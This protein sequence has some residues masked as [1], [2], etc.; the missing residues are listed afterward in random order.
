MNFM[1]DNYSQNIKWDGDVLKTLQPS[2]TRASLKY[3]IET[4]WKN[5]PV[6]R[7]SMTTLIDTDTDFAFDRAK[8]RVG[9]C[10]LQNRRCR[11]GDQV[12]P[13]ARLYDGPGGKPVTFSLSD[14]E[15][16]VHYTRANV[17]REARALRCDETNRSV[18]DTAY[19]LDTPS[20]GL[21]GDETP[22][23][24]TYRMSFPGR[25]GNEE[26]YMVINRINTRDAEMCPTRVCEHNQDRCPSSMCQI[27]GSERCIPK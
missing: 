21:P 23:H 8:M 6:F 18:C 11:T 13:S 19:S 7:E 4:L 14:D 17:T 22:L 25:D 10:D 15:G 27:D 3:N 26:D 1:R 20:L 16:R 5:D 24:E 9:R 12:R 2:T